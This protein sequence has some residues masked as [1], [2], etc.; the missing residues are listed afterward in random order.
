MEQPV[1]RVG[2]MVAEAGKEIG[3]GG[4]RR[5]LYIMVRSSMGSFPMLPRR[6]E[7]SLGG[8]WKEG[9][10]DMERMLRM[11][12]SSSELDTDE[13]DADSGDGAVDHL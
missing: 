12:L 6:V 5:R 3:S 13:L 2:R 9:Y 7:G 1:R 11:R 10:K 8:A 4:G